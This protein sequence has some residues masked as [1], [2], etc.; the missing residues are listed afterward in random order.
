M[1]AVNVVVCVQVSEERLHVQ[2]SSAM[3]VRLRVHAH[4]Q[5]VYNDGRS[6]FINDQSP[7]EFTKL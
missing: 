5:I 7:T 2:L 1:H 4:V 3:F 6:S